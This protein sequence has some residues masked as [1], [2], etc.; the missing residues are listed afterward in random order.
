MRQ[1]DGVNVVGR[2]ECN[3]ELLENIKGGQKFK[4]VVIGEE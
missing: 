3:I 1:F 4:F 2:C